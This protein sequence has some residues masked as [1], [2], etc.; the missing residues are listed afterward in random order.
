MEEIT[1]QSTPPRWEDAPEWAN[2]LTVDESGFWMWHE[3]KPDNQLDDMPV[4]QWWSYGRT[5]AARENSY[6]P[7]MFERCK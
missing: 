2:Y 6:E 1:N 7:Q 3:K 4:M 5:K